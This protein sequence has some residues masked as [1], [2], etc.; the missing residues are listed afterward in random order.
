MTDEKNSIHGG[1]QSSDVDNFNEGFHLSEKQKKIFY[2]ICNVFITELKLGQLNFESKE[3]FSKRLFDRLLITA[4]QHQLIR[5]SS[6]LKKMS[7]KGMTNYS[8]TNSTK[9]FH[10]LDLNQRA[11]AVA[12]WNTSQ[13]A[14]I[15]QFYKT[16]F[17]LTCSAFWL[18]PYDFYPAIGYPGPDPEINGS[19][20]KGR[21]FPE[22]EFIEITEDTKN[23]EFDVVIVGSGAGGSV[24][25]ARLARKSGNSV[26]VIEKGHYYHQSE[27]TLKEKDGY[28]KLYE[29]G[30]GMLSEDSSMAVFSG[31]NFGGGTTIG[32]STSAE[33]SHFVREEWANNFGLTNFME[34]DYN[35]SLKTIQNRLGVGTTNIIQNESNKILISGCKKLGA[36]VATVSQSSA[37]KPHECGWCGFG[38]RYGEKQSA[39]MTYLKDAKEYGVKFIQDCFVERVLIENSKVVGVEAT[40]NKGEIK[41]RI[42]AKK[43]IVACGGL[44]SPALLL[45][46]G[47]KN[48][49]IGKNLFTN[50]IAAVYGIFP[51]K[52][53]KTY[54]GT[55]QSAVCDAKENVD[56]EHYGARIFVG[57]YHPATMSTSFPW[58]SSLQHK[59]FML[60]YNHIVPLLTITRDR[61]PGQIRTDS[62]GLPKLDYKL[63][64]HDADSAIAGLQTSL[65]ILVAAGATKIGTCQAEVEEFEITGENPLNDAKFLQYLEKVKK[66]GVSS[67]QACLSSIHQMG[68]CRMGDD[69]AKS[70][71]NPLGE[72]W[73]VKNLYVA[74]SSVFPTSAG[75]SPMITTMSIGFYVAKCILAEKEFVKKRQSS[76]IFGT[77]LNGTVIDNTT[78]EKRTSRRRSILSSFSSKRSSTAN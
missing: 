1:S 58:K 64:Q 73:E 75:A 19:R 7:S 11:A 36:P 28:E 17:N 5:I 18:N 6:M 53:V 34:D 30:G 47:L 44:H 10:E 12:K 78:V 26:L 31:S 50:P 22:Y 24:A 66:V 65:K 40:V 39:V 48:K 76:I 13:K 16:I 56:G 9:L 4:P 57:S 27:L 74:D 70:V 20:F 51:N 77:S 46:S 55:I 54:S 35:D 15:R 72:T 59:Q 14:S 49:N 45:R 29:L 32:W 69:P 41:F 8:M 38:C 25:A 2:A 60:Q 37:S 33:P 63:S 23:L 68:T 62:S 67:G 43:V 3:D 52:D 71:V 42:N 21:T 61:D